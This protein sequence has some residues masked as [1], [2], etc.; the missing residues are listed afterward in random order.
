MVETINARFDNGKLTTSSLT[1]EIALTYNPADFSTPFGTESI[2]LEN[3]SSLEK[4]APN[5]VFIS[6]TPDKEGEYSVNLSSLGRTQVAFKY[7][8]RVNDS[9]QTAPLLITPAYKIE[10]NQLSVILSYSLDPTFA[11]Q[12]QESITFSNVMLALA[13][14][15]TKATSCQSRPVGTF[16][17]ERNLIFWQLG[18]I[19]LAP[20]APPQK[21][22]ARFATESEAQGGSAEV[23]W[24]VSSSSLDSGRGISVLSQRSGAGDGSDPFADEGAAAHAG[25]W[26]P[27]PGARKMV[28][29]SYVAK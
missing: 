13:V 23:R 21:L 14:E 15:G 19:T 8:V 18:E 2:R 28:S 10:P 1:G 16:S 7:Q 22:L 17:A 29:G 11:L 5:P 24:E 4:V 25:T 26:V 9:A 20:G 12:G 6:Q 27:V 3:F